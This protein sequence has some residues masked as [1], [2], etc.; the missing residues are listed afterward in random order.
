MS[1]AN[2]RVAF[3]LI[4][5]VVTVPRGCYPR[6]AAS[7]GVPHHSICVTVLDAD[8]NKPRWRVP[9]ALRPADSYV[10]L[11]AVTNHKGRVVFQLPSPLP[12]QLV[13][14]FDPRDFGLCSNAVFRT[15]DIL[16]DGVVG[17][18][19]CKRSGPEYSGKAV[20]GELIVFGKKVSPW[21]RILQEIP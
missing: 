3:A 11:N 13:L 18:D 21:E 20:P 8:S 9:T 6:A 15:D 12:E 16:K 17:T 10:V 7:Q 2:L 1:E 19:T 5:A 4:L 14:I